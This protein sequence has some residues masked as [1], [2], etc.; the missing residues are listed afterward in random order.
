[1][2]TDYYIIWRVSVR[3]GLLNPLLFLMEGL[4]L[5]QVR[6]RDYGPLGEVATYQGDT[7]TSAWTL[8][9]Q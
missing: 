9:W 7:S 1:M 8:G 5:S 2:I 4:V 3:N 6:G